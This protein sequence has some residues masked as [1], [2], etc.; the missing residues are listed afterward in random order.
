MDGDINS[1]HIPNAD[2]Q[3]PMWRSVARWLEK[4]A[5]EY[6]HKYEQDGMMVTPVALALQMDVAY[7]LLLDCPS[8]N[9]ILAQ[10]PDLEDM[11]VY[12]ADFKDQKYDG[13]YQHSSRS[14]ALDVSELAALSE[15]GL[16]PHFFSNGSHE[17]RHAYQYAVRRGAHMSS[18]P[19]I[20][21]LRS[22]IY[23]ADANA[24]QATVA[25]EAKK[26]SG[27]D[28]FW[29]FCG[30]RQGN[31]AK[32]FIELAEEDLLTY[33]TGEAQQAAF[34]AFFENEGKMN[35]YA[36]HTMD[37]LAEHMAVSPYE[38]AERL[39]NY[40]R[41][42]AKIRED[43]RVIKALP[44]PGQQFKAVN[45]PLATPSKPELGRNFA[46]ALEGPSGD[47]LG[48]PVYGLFDDFDPK[49]VD[50]Y[51]R[52]LSDSRYAALLKMTEEVRKFDSAVSVE[53]A[54]MRDRYAQG[55]AKGFESPK[56]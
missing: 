20:M 37:E 4:P 12:F 53:L 47:L 2:T 26:F 36:D 43:K 41:V 27:V 8:F 38:A 5:S 25:F 9:A 54:K 19:H 3:V 56:F 34:L 24:F 21:A 35:F 15:H 45:A 14:I 17:Y 39:F 44:K 46:M 6:A 16:L 1:H 48:R 13:V 29:D 7:A 11:R 30:I 51:M 32:A 18:N 55:P 10:A 42:Q 50:Y 40:E 28:M 23:E 33:I 22:F 31:I 49:S 52:G